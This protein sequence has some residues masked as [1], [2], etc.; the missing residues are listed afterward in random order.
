MKQG[1]QLRMSQHLALT[2]QLQQSIRLLQLSTLELNQ[3]IEQLLADNPLLERADSP[4]DSSLRLEGDGSVQSASEPSFEG[5]AGDGGDDGAK[6]VAVEQ[7]EEVQVDLGQDLLMGEPRTRGALD[8]DAEPPQLGGVTE[9]LREHLLS[10]LSTTKAMQRDR[11]LVAVLIDA[12]DEDGY[13]RHATRRDCRVA[14]G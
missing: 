12:I 6:D 2:P 13:L 3:E 14:A 5:S 8:D 1:L 9:T 10:Q 11:A 7:R 4:F